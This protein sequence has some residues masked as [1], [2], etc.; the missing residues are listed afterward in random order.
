MAQITPALI[1]ELRDRTGVGMGKCKEALEAANGDIELAINNLRKSG[2]A[3]AIKKE[4]RSANEGVIVTAENNGVISLVE[5]R[6]ETD[7]VIRNDK[8]QQFAQSLA[9]DAARLTPA[10]LEEFL[11]K[12]STKEPT[13][14]IDEYR[15]T[16]VQSIGEN[17]Q[18]ARLHL[19]KK[20]PGRSFGL[21]SHLGGKILT[22]VEID[23]SPGEE[24]LA[25][26]IAM[27]VAAAHPEYL[28]PEKVP[29]EIISHEKEIA[30]SQIQGKPP[31]IVDKIVEGKINAFFDSVCLLRQ[32]FI[33][34][35][36]LTIADLVAQKS[37]TLG[38]PLALT[39]FLRW[40]IGG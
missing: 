40:S 36:S 15:A 5:V 22:A 33:R 13:L 39:H 34:D 29:Q 24:A 19:L 30:K 12:K 23:G 38:K 10:S 7:F 9:E 6:A 26:E 25:K 31:A 3:S 2:M 8:F 35:D 20:A 1:K 11:K 32:K 18:I 4:G 28:S 17:I 37:K 14:T 16:L 27:H 21:Y